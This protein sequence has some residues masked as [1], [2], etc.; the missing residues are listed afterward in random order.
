YVSVG[1]GFALVVAAWLFFR[2]TG[3]LFNPNIATALLAIGVI[4][5]L[6]W[7]LLVV[8]QLVGAVCATAVVQ[9]L[10]PGQ[11][12]LTTVPS[13]GINKAQALFIEMFA[14]TFLTFAVLMLGVE[15]HRTTPFAPIGVGITLFVCELWSIPLTGGA[16]NTA[17]AFGPA[18][19][20]GFDAS[21]WIYW[22]G[23]TMGALLAAAVY[24]FAKRH[25]YW[26]LVPDQDSVDSEKS[27]TVPSLPLAHLSRVRPRSGTVGPR[28][29][30]DRNR[31][32]GS[33]AP[34]RLNL[35]I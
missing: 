2:V 31:Q 12:Q 29:Q 16:I 32:S 3:A 19:L 5:P 24:V 20:T 15:K 11:L 22:A 14:T 33:A 6:R 34:P 13:L 25:R 4:G 23:P 21:H 17:R 18:V 7:L 26:T 10:M 30:E 28:G 27:P 35:D 9:G 8:A 1:F